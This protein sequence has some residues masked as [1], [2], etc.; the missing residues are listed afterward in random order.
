MLRTIGG[1]LQRSNAQ[2]LPKQPRM[3]SFRS[4]DNY[5]DTS[6]SLP[7][8]SARSLAGRVIGHVLSSHLIILALLSTYYYFQANVDPAKV[9]IL[10]VSAACLKASSSLV[11]IDIALLFLHLCPNVGQLFKRTL[12]LSCWN[13]TGH[14]NAHRHLRHCTILF[15]FLHTVLWWILSAIE[16]SHGHNNVI[17][18]LQVNLLTSTGWTGHALLL[19][20]SLSCIR[21]SSFSMASAVFETWGLSVM[22]MCIV[23]CAAHGSYSRAGMHDSTPMSNVAWALLLFGLLVYLI[24]IMFAAQATEFSSVSKIIRHPSGVFELHLQKQGLEP[25]IGQACPALSIF[26]LL[27][28]SQ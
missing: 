18:Y 20:F 1:I 23:L 15:T 13:V 12:K 14:D 9:K 4:L 6:G 22:V 8:S 5:V 7:R 10:I 25:C 2:S 26:E 19:I 28:H 3:P 17:T 16:A 24:E 21:T 11:L 27:A